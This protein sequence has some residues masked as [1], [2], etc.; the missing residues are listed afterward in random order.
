MTE[1]TNPNAELREALS[2][3]GITSGAK[4]ARFLKSSGVI[5]FLRGEGGWENARAELRLP[6]R[7]TLT[8]YALPEDER[9]RE[10]C[11]DRAV[12]V[13]REVTGIFEWSKAPFSNCW[14]PSDDIERLHEEFDTRELP[15]SA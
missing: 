5:F 9:V 1:H 14:L 7:E 15:Q 3:K 2:K 10:A 8:F 11:V 4:L 13:A 6:D 12:D